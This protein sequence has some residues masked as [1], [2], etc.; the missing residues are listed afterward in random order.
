MKGETVEQEERGQR[1]GDSGAGGERSALGRRLQGYRER[2]WSRRREV[3]AGETSPGMKGETVEQEERGQRWGDVSRDTG[4]DSGAGG[5]RSALGRRLQGY[6]ERQWSR[7][8]EVSAGETSPGIQGETVEQEERGQRWGDVSRDTGRDSGAGGERSALGRRLQGYRERQWSRRREVSAGETSPGI[9]GETVEQEERGQ[10]WGDVSRDT[11]RDSGAGGERSAL[12]RRLQGYRERQWSRRREVS[13]GETSPGIQGETVE[14][15]ERGQRWGD[16][17]RDTGRDSGAG[18]ERSA[19]GRR[20]QGYRERQ[21]SRR[22]EVS[23]TQR[24]TATENEQTLR[25]REKEGV[26]FMEC[27]S[28][29]NICLLQCLKVCAC[30]FVCE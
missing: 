20:L 27:G 3:S 23:R 17:S 12:G 21:W 29:R 15:E 8:R 24:T 18:G 26:D 11:G 22:R 7:R 4:R 6:R 28:T 16:V 30:G 2:Q 9:Q 14:Q 10:R 1:W 5:E 13:A 25:D 19:L